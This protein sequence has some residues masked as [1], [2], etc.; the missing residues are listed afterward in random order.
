MQKC[1]L[2]FKVA[3]KYIK[4]QSQHSPNP[5]PKYRS[6][7]RG[8][9]GRSFAGWPDGK[10]TVISGMLRVSADRRRP[11]SVAVTCILHL[12]EERGEGG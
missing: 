4:M 12:G 5:S 3:Y 9:G 10:E 2:G 6:L 11:R 8:E 7:D 1:I